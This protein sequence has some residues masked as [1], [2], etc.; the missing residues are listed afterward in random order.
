MIMSTAD[1]MCIKKTLKLLM[2]SLIKGKGT[3]KEELQI[4]KRGAN[5]E[6]MLSL[7]GSIL[8][9]CPYMETPSSWCDIS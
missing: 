2:A 4:R 5:G 3:Q 9:A 7:W 1:S 8:G 6:L